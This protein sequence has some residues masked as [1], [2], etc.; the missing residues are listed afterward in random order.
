MEREKAMKIERFSSQYLSS[1]MYLVEENFTA[2]L[3]DPFINEKL[4]WNTIS[5]IYLTHEHF[6]HISGVNWWK[7]RTDGRILCSKKCAERI[8][9]TR[10]NLSHY[11]RAFMQAQTWMPPE[12]MLYV[13]DYVCHAD[14]AFAGEKTHKWEGHELYFHAT[15]GHSPGSSCMILDNAY[16]FSGDS[17]LRDYPVITRLVGGDRAVWEQCSKPWFKGLIKQMYVM[18]GHFES[19]CLADYKL[20]EVE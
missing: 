16:L 19:F 17:I 20:W 13:D 7:E 15:E 5:L 9:D 10:H 2:V 14:I 8:E 6:D 11:F 18:P 3:I 4:Y 12:N 1:N